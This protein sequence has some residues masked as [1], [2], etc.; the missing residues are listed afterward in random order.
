MILKGVL[1]IF[2][3]VGGGGK[4]EPNV[5]LWC[6]SSLLSSVVPTASGWGA[7]ITAFWLT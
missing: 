6:F 3:G 4:G 1:I 2:S 5:L 7:G